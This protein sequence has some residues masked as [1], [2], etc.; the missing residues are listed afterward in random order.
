MLALA[1][2]SIPDR[3]VFERERELSQLLCALENDNIT[4]RSGNIPDH[5]LL[6]SGVYYGALLVLG[7]CR[8]LP[9][10]AFAEN[11]FSGSDLAR[12]TSLYTNT[13]PMAGFYT[14][15]YILSYCTLASWAVA[16]ELP[17]DFSFS[18]CDVSNLLFCP[19]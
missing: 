2:A 12:Y 18:C 16:Y 9:A 8:D 4:E 3:I 7:T 19:C 13:T 5:P 6:R 10:D 11:A 15:F 14:T 1:L 17:P